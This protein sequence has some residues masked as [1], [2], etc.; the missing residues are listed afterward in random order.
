MAT[1]GCVLDREL[2][3]QACGEVCFVIGQ[4]SRTGAPPTGG[5]LPLAIRCRS[6]PLPRPSSAG[7]ASGAARSINSLQCLAA[8]RG[9]VSFSG[10]IFYNAREKVGERRGEWNGCKRQL[11]CP[12]RVRRRDCI[13]S[14]RIS[15]VRPGDRHC[16]ATVPLRAGGPCHRMVQARIQ[17]RADHPDPVLLHVP[18]RD[19]VRAAHGA[20]GH[21]PLDRRGGDRFR[22]G[23]GGRGQS[24]A[25]RRHRVLFDDRLGRG[26]DPD[27]LRFPARD[28]LLAL[29]AA[30]GVHAA[31]SAVPLLEAQHHAAVHLVGD[32]RL[33]G[34]AGG[35]AGLSS[36][37]T[38]SIWASTSSRSRRPARGCAIFSRS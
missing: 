37:A 32:R 30:S 12:K 33:A 9:L 34:G 5:N 24:G 20:A 18:A 10:R 3:F 27:L 25:N 38:S 35:R 16:V 8:I 36:T 15:L 13:Q 22:A 1:Q 21:R 26:H 19:E 14:C 4:R 31:A 28:H 11:W 23:D 7:F 17:P 29:G 6:R 2:S